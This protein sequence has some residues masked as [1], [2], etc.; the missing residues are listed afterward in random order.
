[1]VNNS[2]RITSSIPMATAISA[3]CKDQVTGVGSRSMVLRR[4]ASTEQD[5]LHQDHWLLWYTRLMNC[6][7][8]LLGSRSILQVHRLCNAVLINA[9]IGSIDTRCP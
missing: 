5:L 8:M 6:S 2:L 9:G 4:L 1:M 7:S 3:H